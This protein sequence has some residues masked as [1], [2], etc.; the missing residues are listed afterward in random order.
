MTA[1]GGAGLAPGR[2]SVNILK[3]LYKNM[4]L[5]LPKKRY[6]TAARLQK[7]YATG[8]LSPVEALAQAGRQI[9]YKNPF[10][11]AFSHVDMAGALQ[12]ARAAEKRWRQGRPLSPLDGVP[13]TVKDWYDIKGLPTRMG[14]VVTDARPKQHNAPVVEALLK[15]GAVIIG[16]TTLPE[17][18]HKGVTDSR[19]HGITRNPHDLTRTCGGSSGG[20]AVA[21]AAGFA[22]L[23]L[24]SDAGGSIRIPA[25]FCGVFGFKPSPGLVPAY[26][27]SLFS[28]LSSA[29]PLTLTAADAALMMDVIAAPCPRDWHA[30]PDAKEGFD[31]DGFERGGFEKALRRALPRLSIGWWDEAAGH[32]MEKDVEKVLKQALEKIRPLGVIERVRLDT[33]DMIDVFNAHW[34]AAASYYAGLW[35]APLRG[36]MDPRFL[37]WAE[38][39]AA[40]SRN[41]YL[42]AELARMEIG[43]RFKMALEQYDVILSP[44]TAMTAFAAGQNMPR[45]ASGQNKGKFWDDWTP[46]TYAAN[47]ARLPAASL[48]AGFTGEGLP[49]GLQ[50]MSGYLKDKFLLRVCH[51]IEKVL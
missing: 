34:M 7:L 33:H 46:F 22:P 48:P 8:R 26:P 18:G 6:L 49:V 40:Q 39:G 2:P 1:R 10:V 21:A 29:G 24:G 19:L 30:L 42:K 37:H 41:D 44:T 23:N 9:V 43:S 4:S 25:S 45:F 11:N 36:K 5:V 27:P 16:K 38:R 50:V 3:Y 20:A 28:T 15:A 17:M 47:L 35:P 32:R 51:A 31:K 13:V 12:A 14:S